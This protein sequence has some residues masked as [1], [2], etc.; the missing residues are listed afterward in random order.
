MRQ[1]KETDRKSRRRIERE[2]Y[3]ERERQ[4]EIQKGLIWS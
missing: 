1:K 4:R 2:I 3:T